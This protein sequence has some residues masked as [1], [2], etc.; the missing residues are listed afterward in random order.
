MT[1]GQRPY[2]EPVDDGVREQGRAFLPV[3]VERGDELQHG[4]LATTRSAAASTRP[5]RPTD[6]TFSSG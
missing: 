5:S 3:G 6:R 1:L 4:V 2:D